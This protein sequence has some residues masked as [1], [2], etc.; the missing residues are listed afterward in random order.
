MLNWL[1]SRNHHLEDPDD[2]PSQS[3][4]VIILWVY[5][6]QGF[7]CLQG[8]IKVSHLITIVTDKLKNVVWISR[9]LSWKINIPSIL[10]LPIHNVSPNKPFDITLFSFV[11]LVSDQEETRFGLFVVTCSSIS[12][13]VVP[14]EVIVRLEITF[15]RI[16]VHQNIIELLQQEKAWCHTL[17]SGNRITFSRTCSYNLEKLLGCLQMFSRILLV[18]VL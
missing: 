8:V 4:F 7:E 9:S 10:S 12:E 3:I 11:F 17:P 2:C 6:F 1:F 5:L 15:N 18:T 14:M 16:Q 13:G